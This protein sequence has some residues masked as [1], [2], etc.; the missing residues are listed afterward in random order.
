MDLTKTQYAFFYALLISVSVVFLVLMSGLFQPIFWATLLGVI[1][2]PLMKRIR[3]RMPDRPSL[4]A[5][6]TTLTILV[7]VVV[8]SFVV[9]VAVANEGVRLY[10]GIQQGRIDPTTVVRRFESAVPQSAEL[11]Q[12]LGIDPED[13]R[14]KVSELAVGVSSFV[15]DLAIST[16][17]N[18]T[19]FAVMFFIMIYLLFFALRDGKEILET[20]QR[21]LPLP[22]DK[23]RDIFSKF[24]EVGRATLKGTLV[25]GVV[26][27]ALGGIMFAIL[28][29][30]AAVFW[31]VVMIFLS[32]LPA[33]GSAL[34]WGPAAV[35]LLVTGQ[36]IKG[37]ILVVYGILVIGLVDNVLRPIL[38]GRD[39][40]MPDWLILLATLGGLTVFGIS[41]FVIGPIIA[42]M[43]L[44]TWVMFGEFYPPPEASK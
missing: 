16:G 11:L 20:A 21:V 5:L 44:S 15:A 32:V 1:F 34:V 2:R 42:A 39:T 27:G 30:Q 14:A 41:G 6:L 33:V 37:I 10:Q 13:V 36:Y 8:P 31:G 25:V 7:T 18:I 38:V 29:I 4:A 40:K 17:Q 12:R 19:R 24:S 3:S 28:G 22:D 26:Q 35:I 23:E 9:S 43:F